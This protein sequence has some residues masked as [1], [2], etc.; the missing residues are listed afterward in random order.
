M[1][2]LFIFGIIAVKTIILIF[3]G[4]ITFIALRAYNRTESRSL[5]V[6]ALGF[7]IVTLGA[8]TGGIV[9]QVFQISLEAGIFIDGLLTAIGFGVILISLYRNY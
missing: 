6:L 7:G 4:L 1:N 2:E 5:G 8:L 3:G 9:H